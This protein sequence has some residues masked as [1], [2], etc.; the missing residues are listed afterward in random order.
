MTRSMAK[1]QAGD[2]QLE[3]LLTRRHASSPSPASLADGAGAW[4]ELSNKEQSYPRAG[5]L[6]NEALA[7]GWLRTSA[8][9]ALGNSVAVG[10]HESVILI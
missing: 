1:A 6:G 4:A 3:S 2:L 10:Q 5:G 8:A 7:P 9:C